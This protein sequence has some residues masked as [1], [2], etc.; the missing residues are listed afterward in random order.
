MNIQRL[1]VRWWL[2]ALIALWVAGGFDL[3]VLAQDD[4]DLYELASEAADT[5]IELAETVL[6]EDEQEHGKQW[7]TREYLIGI[8]LGWGL[9]Q[10]IVLFLVIRDL[11]LRKK[12]GLVLAGWI[13]AIGLLGIAAGFIYWLMKKLTVNKSAVS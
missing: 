11:R 10:L 4:E 12:S 1:G 13:I 3:A 2:S 6:E 9:L 5:E 8:L 7:L